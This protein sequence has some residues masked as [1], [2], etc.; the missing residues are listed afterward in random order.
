MDDDDDDVGGSA[1]W[2]GYRS[3]GSE[4]REKEGHAWRRMLSEVEA[5]SPKHPRVDRGAVPKT[6]LSEKAAEVSATGS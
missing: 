4:N 5:P 3:T 6:S 2:L 1:G